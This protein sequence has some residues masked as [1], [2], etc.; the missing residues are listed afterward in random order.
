MAAPVPSV[1]PPPR[2]R[3]RSAARRE[4]DHVVEVVRSRARTSNHA[5]PLTLM[6]D[7]IVEGFLREVVNAFPN[8]KFFKLEVG[9]FA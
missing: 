1:H 9:A 7:V 2:G 8:L 4:P 3:R 6:P 5:S